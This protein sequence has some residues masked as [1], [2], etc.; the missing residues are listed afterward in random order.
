MILF[1]FYF[2]IGS[3]L[4]SFFLCLIFQ[5]HYD[6]FHR[7]SQCETCQSPLAFYQLIPCV[8][9]FY[10]KHQCPLCKQPISPLHPIWEGILGSI[11]AI[12]FSYYG[13]SLYSGQLY[14]LLLLL[15][16][17]S[18]GDLLYYEL[19]LGLFIPQTIGVLIYY[20]LTETPI[21][22]LQPCILTII[23]I[24]INLLFKNY[25]GSG[26]LYFFIALS[27]IVPWI[28]LLKILWLAC[29]L[30]LLCLFIQKEKKAPFIPYLSVSIVILF[31]LP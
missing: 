8:S 5:L 14:S 31:N 13:I 9:Y 18:L 11:T 2:I 10:C 23:F 6:D 20:Y 26:D 21:Y 15:L 1:I 4:A 25:I 24:I 17:T 28:S 30:C 3:C 16:I 12:M 19:Y 7:H 22:F 27:F 29:L